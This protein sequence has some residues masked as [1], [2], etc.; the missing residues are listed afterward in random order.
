M[1]IIQKCMHDINFNIIVVIDEEIDEDA[2]S[3]LNLTIISSVI[4]KAGPRA[5]FWD[6]WSLWKVSFTIFYLF[7]CVKFKNA[8]SINKMLEDVFIS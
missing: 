7:F 2:F 1:W 4:T 6:K 8:F 5:K 3:V